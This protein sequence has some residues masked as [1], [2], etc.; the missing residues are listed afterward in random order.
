MTAEDLEERHVVFAL[1][2]KPRALNADVRIATLWPLM[3][4][5]TGRATARILVAFQAMVSRGGTA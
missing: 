4:F 2:Q 1:A 5:D 3:D